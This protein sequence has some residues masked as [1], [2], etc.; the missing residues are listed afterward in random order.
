ML[1]YGQAGKQ[2][3]LLWKVAIVI[4]KVTKL[5]VNGTDT[6]PEWEYRSAD[7]PLVN[8]RIG[9]VQHVAVH[10][11]MGEFRYDQPIITCRPGP[12]CVAVTADGSLALLRS[13]DLVLMDL[14]APNEFP[15]TSFHKLGFVSLEF[16]RGGA[17]IGE[18]IEQAAAREV[19][20]EVGYKV[21]KVERLDRGNADTAFFPI[22]TTTCLV[23]I[24]RKSPS[25]L[26]PDP[27]E[28]TEVTFVTADEFLSLVADGKILC[29][30]TKAAYLSYMASLH[31]KSPV[32]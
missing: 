25:E 28:D 31:R 18:S 19:E 11:E 13:S 3:K 16:P 29:S 20:E 21:V 1:G 12:V 15:I 17:E 30:Q 32:A 6:K 5:N 27:L 14:A 10:D 9:W 8:P 22:S 26:N 7:L 4:E 23:T 2:K 24:D